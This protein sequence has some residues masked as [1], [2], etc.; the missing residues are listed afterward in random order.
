MTEPVEIGY[1][2]RKG[3][4]IFHDEPVYDG[5]CGSKRMAGIFVVPEEGVYPHYFAEALGEAREDF[6]QELGR[7]YP[8]EPATTLDEGRTIFNRAVVEEIARIAKD[9][10]TQRKG[11]RNGA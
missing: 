6:A 2:C 11:E 5:A 10:S 9:V 4:F 1:L 7:M 3:H 8:E